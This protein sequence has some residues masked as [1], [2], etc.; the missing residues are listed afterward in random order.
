MIDVGG[1]NSLWAVPQAC[2][3]VSIKE[4]SEQPIMRQLVN[5]IHSSMASASDRASRFL[6]CVPAQISLDVGF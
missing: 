3:P 2:G 1:T 5:N 6:P 4:Q